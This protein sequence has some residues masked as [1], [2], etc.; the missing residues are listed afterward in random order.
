M[1]ILHFAKS[2]VRNSYTFYLFHKPIT[3]RYIF[4][5]SFFMQSLFNFLNSIKFPIQI[6][7]LQKILSQ[8]P[9]K[10][11]S[12]FL[13]SAISTNLFLAVWQGTITEV[14]LILMGVILFIA[15]LGFFIDVGWKELIENSW[16]YRKYFIEK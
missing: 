5:N 1:N 9:I 10:Y 16:F 3:R 2:I 6:R 15:F 4:E 7:N 14:G 12:I 13:F 11:V 8:K